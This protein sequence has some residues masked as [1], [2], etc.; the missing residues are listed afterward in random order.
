MPPESSA[1]Y[2]RL[3][4]LEADERDVPRDDLAPIALG[5]VGE[6]EADVVA[7]REPRE[8]A[9]LLEDE[10]AFP[11]R[12]RHP[13]AVDLDRARRC[14]LEAGDAVQERRLP[15]A[16]R[17]DDGEELLGRDVEVDAREHVDRLLPLRKDF[18]TPATRIFGTPLTP[19]PRPGA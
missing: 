1:G 3:E 10:D 14:L 7:H 19:A 5:P 8:D 15:A 17:P 18:E 9:G 6:A 4:S 16:R 11:R 13:L 2:A 12:A